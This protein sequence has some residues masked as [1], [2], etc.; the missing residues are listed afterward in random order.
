MLAVAHHAERCIRH[1]IDGWRVEQHIDQRAQ[2]IARGTKAE[3]Y[4]QQIVHHGKKHGSE[5][6]PARFFVVERGVWLEKAR[7]KQQQRQQRHHRH[8]TGLKDQQIIGRYHTYIL[9][10][11]KQQEHTVRTPLSISHIDAKL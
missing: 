1:K 4:L 11:T 7:R 5:Q 10:A 3:K 8:S 9:H 6:E 2:L